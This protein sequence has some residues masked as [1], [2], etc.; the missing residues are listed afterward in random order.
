[1]AVETLFF[2]YVYA[3]YA[4]F[5]PICCFFEHS[6]K[7]L[8]NQGCKPHSSSLATDLSTKNVR[9]RLRGQKMAFLPT[10]CVDK[11]GS[12][13][14]CYSSRWLYQQ[15]PENAFTHTAYNLSIEKI[16]NK[17]N[18]LYDVLG[19]CTHTC[20]QKMCAT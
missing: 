9:N 19:A 4:Q 16:L 17:F 7:S 11:S 20:P 5:P 6:K 13:E 2:R 3:A 10:R 1:M 8:V 14:K 18:D 15:I 12:C